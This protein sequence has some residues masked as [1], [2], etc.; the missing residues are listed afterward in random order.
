M[1]WEDE[2]R[3]A[4]RMLIFICMIWAA[5]LLA[6]LIKENPEVSVYEGELQTQPMDFAKENLRMGEYGRAMDAYLMEHFVNGDRRKK[7]TLSIEKMLGTREFGDVYLGSDDYLFQKLLPQDYDGKEAGTI[8]RIQ[9]FHELFPDAVVAPIPTKEAIL[10]DKVPLFAPNYRQEDFCKQVQEA[11]PVECYQDV[12][13]LLKEH[14]KE[15]IYYKTDSHLT[16]LASIYLYNDWLSGKNYPPRSYDSG[17]MFVITNSFQ[18]DLIR[19]EI[20][21]DTTDSLMILPKTTVREVT[22]SYDGGEEWKTLY[23]KTKLVSDYAY[24]YYLD[25]NHG[26]TEIHTSYSAQGRE[27]ILIKDSYVNELIPLLVPFYKKIYVLDTDNCTFDINVYVKMHT[28]A[29]TDILW[30]ESVTGMLEHTK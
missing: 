28:H 1:K 5:F 4:R 10:S 19:P 2:K 12:W 18:G 6:N 3:D 30:M 24:D 27:L 29:K 20:E 9:N 7:I 26:L 25:G 22:V 16:M 14:K 21:T 17:T 15:D 23:S 11:L 13:S 8:R